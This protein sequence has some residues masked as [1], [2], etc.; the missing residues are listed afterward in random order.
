MRN[1]SYEIYI[2]NREPSNFSDTISNALELSNNLIEG[3][4]IWNS[5]IDDQSLRMDQM[6]TLQYLMFCRCDLENYHKSH[7]SMTIPQ[8]HLVLSTIR[9]EGILALLETYHI[10]S[11]WLDSVTVSDAGGNIKNDPFKGLPIEELVFVHTALDRTHLLLSQYI[12][13]SRICAFSCTEVESFIRSTLKSTV[14]CKEVWIHQS[15]ANE[16]EIMRLKSD[17]PAVRFRLE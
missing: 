8:C 12:R 15:D 16:A 14:N 3:I 1:N 2:K 10:D 17:F 4:E 5:K 13:P 6:K 11:L 7:L 9:L